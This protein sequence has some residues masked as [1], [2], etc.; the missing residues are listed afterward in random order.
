MLTVTVSELHSF[1]GNDAALP[2]EGVTL[3]GSTLYGTTGLGGNY[4]SGTIF[5]VNTNGTGYQV[6]Y[7]I[8]G[9]YPNSGLTLVGSTLYGTTSEGSHGEGG[10]F[11]INTNGTGYQLLYSFG[12]IAHD[13]E[14]PK[15]GLTLSGSTLYGTTES[16][17]ADSDGTIFS[18]NTDGTGYQTLYSFGSVASDGRSPVAGL[19][20]SGSTLYGTAE[21]GGSHSDGTVFSINTAGTGY[22]TLYSFGSAASDGNSPQS[23][24]TLS[25]S[26]LYGT[27]ESGGGHSDGTIFSIGTGGSYT[28]LY[29]FT[30]G[31]SGGSRPVNGLTLSGSTLYGTTEYGGA[32]GGSTAGD[33]TVFSISTSG[34]GFQILH[35]FTGGTSDGQ[36]PAGL[37]LSGSTLYGTTYEGGSSVGDG[38]VFSVNTDG[39]GYQL[40]QSFPTVSDGAN[41]R[42][43]LA[44]GGSTLYGMTANGGGGVAG[45]GTIFSIGVNGTGYQ[46]LHS[47]TGSTTDGNYP[48]D[49]GLT[50]VGSTLYGTTFQGGSAGDGTIFSMSTNGTGFTL[51]H[52]FTGGT[53]DGEN[54]VGN[55]TLDGT[56]LYGVTRYNGS[57]GNGTIFSINTN[58]TGYTVLYSFTGG[59]TGGSEPYA[60]LT[61]VG[62]T[63]YGTT[64]YGGSAGDGTIFSIGT[65]GT[66]FALLHSFTGGGPLAALVISGSAF[67]GTTGSGG[68]GNDGTIFSINTDG[69][70]YEVLYSFTGGATDGK[71][72]AAD[73]ALVGSTLFGTTAVGGSSNDGTVFAINTNGTGYQELYSFPGGT[74][75][76]SDPGAGLTADGSALFGTA[77][78]GGNS[79]NEG[80]LFSI[81][82]VTVTPSGATN[83]FTASGPA[84]A[85]DSGVGVLAT[86]T[87]L[88]GATMTINNDQSGDV[89]NFTNQNGISGSY[90]GGVLTLS[91]SATVAQYQAALQ[92]VTFSTTSTVGTARS[93]S[94]VATDGSL[95]SN[96]AAETVDVDIPAPIVSSHQ[97]SVSV[98]AGAAVAVD[99]ALTVTSIDSSVTG[100]TVT[101]SNYVS[102]DTLQYTAVS[103]IS[104]VSNTAGVLTLSG[105][106]TPAQYQT[107]LESVTFSST[108]SSLTTRN[109]AIAVNDSNDTGNT[110]GTTSTQITVNA[111]ITVTAAYVAGSS[112]GSSGT[113]NFFG[114]LA[115]H[116]LGNATMPTLGYALQTGASQTTD[117]PWTNINTISVTFSEAVYN[118]GLGSLELVGG[119]GGGAVA[120][121]NGGTA[122]GFVSDGNNTYSWTF[123]SSLGNNKYVF[124][125]A[126]IGSSFGTANSTQVTDAS[127]AGI[128]GTFATGQ[129]FPSG[130]GLAGSTF[131]FRFSVLPN[132]GSQQGQVNAADSAGVK[133]VLN[134]HENNANYSPYFDYNGAGIITAGEA[135]QAAASLNTKQSGITQPTA[136]ADLQDVGTTGD[137]DGS[138]G[139]DMTGLAA[140]RAGDRQQLAGRHHERHR[141]RDDGEQFGQRRFDRYN[142]ARHDQRVG[143]GQFRLGQHFGLDDHG[144]R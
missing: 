29:S 106:A 131:D 33:G 52:S 139:T 137:T 72:P 9:L 122:T 16:G 67:Y 127:G 18:I 88:T 53:S 119:T 95:E 99:S 103:P 128:S 69:T 136:P 109:I 38:T 45:D 123:P 77:G 34:T 107:A 104:I 65:N 56:T 25:G 83:T 51:L 130:N 73:L 78:F 94:I 141:Q 66:G 92:S 54:P 134:D 112:W 46:I 43:D 21:S 31:A 11:S 49:N 90:T 1:V 15:G 41:P 129:A 50:L 26:T 74:G 13:G 82:G 36:D 37:A 101:I 96:P 113:E 142:A 44:L 59:A 87:G 39:T 89:L 19:T 35:S 12:G 80:V 40:L 100:A 3:S 60:G 32:A 75:G 55:L 84:V 98:T 114:Y 28:S 14:Q 120:P 70:G 58:G 91:G 22:Q 81:S 61:L 124:A 27:T 118:I 116:G 64:L 105:T 133:A 10:I 4:N 135:S 86:D 93:I 63:L 2:S 144:R 23:G 30:A 97:A 102:G 48:N 8:N 47:F 140:R 110:P 68:S 111:P 24:L 126:T 132:D 125:I 71:D 20:V 62:S 76:G 108:S 121:P 115:S 6:L 57:A 17:G 85:V 138:D 5:S 117:L 42:T 7:T 79:N 143:F